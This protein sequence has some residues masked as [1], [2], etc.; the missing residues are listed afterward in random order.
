MLR[1]VSKVTVNTV[2]LI[3]VVFFFYAVILRGEECSEGRGLKR[4][5]VPKANTLQGGSYREVRPW[6]SEL[7]PN[8]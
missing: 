7:V 4:G 8:G 5:L 2:F 6:D 3:F 1:Q